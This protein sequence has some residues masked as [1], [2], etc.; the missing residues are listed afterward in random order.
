MRRHQCPWG[1][2]RGVP[3]SFPNCQECCIRAVFD[4]GVI[5]EIDRNLKMCS[6]PDLALRRLRRSISSPPRCLSIRARFNLSARTNVTRTRSDIP[7]SFPLT[8]FNHRQNEGGKE[9]Q[10]RKSM[11]KRQP[12]IQQ[13]YR[14]VA[15]SR[16]ARCRQLLIV[17]RDLRP[18]R[19]LEEAAHCTSALG[20]KRTHAAQQKGSYSITSSARTSKSKKLRAAQ[21]SMRR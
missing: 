13:H 20:Q 12:P 9:K 19:M 3:P 4:D 17:S 11:R 15:Q 16:S 18:S 1:H 21:F 8:L 6:L 5:E 7:A 14:M 2:N 10:A